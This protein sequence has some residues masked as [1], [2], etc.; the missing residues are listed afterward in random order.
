[1]L[2]IKSI[3]PAPLQGLNFRGMVST[4]A[5]SPSNDSTVSTRHMRHRDRSR[6]MLPPGAVKPDYS[7]Y[8]LSNVPSTILSTFG[9]DG[10]RPTLPKDAFGDVETSG[11]ENVILLL[12]DGLGYNEWKRQSGQGFIGAISK[13]GSVRPMTTVFPSTTA[14]ALTTIST[15]LTPQEHGLPEWFVYMEE[16]GEIIVP[17]PFTR[18]GDSGRDTLVGAFDPRNLFDGQTVF[19]RLKREG[20]SCTSLTNRTLANTAYTKVS[21]AG[22][23]VV[24][25]NT[26][27]DLTV[28][29]RRLVERSRGKNLFYAY[30]SYVDTIEHIYGPGTDEAEVEASLI[31]HA[32][33]EGFLSKLDREAAKKTLIVVTA[34]HG[35]IKIAPE[36]T[37]YMNR[38]GKLA[39]ALERAPSGAMI[40]AW[41][42]ARDAYMRVDPS[43]LDETKEYLE[44]KLAGT[45][46]VLRTEDAMKEGLFGINRPTMKFRRRIGNLM[47]LPHGTKTVWFRYKKGESLDMRGHHGGL[48]ADE[49]TIPLA[50]ARASD[51]Q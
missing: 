49:M 51:I 35:Q 41:G 37:L 10:T 32:F 45:A 11:V 4:S 9:I 8:C 15:G 20:V 28:S 27:S 1:M 17:L 24:A 26:A 18:V 38:F 47:V 40:P 33:Q 23:G 5:R 19:Q 50:A 16:L 43:R 30:W 36:K 14:A 34:D 13:K 48:T 6:S 25:Y 7:R 21:M 3:V 46:S 42:S 44:D 39:K 2:A 12:C 29:L 31:S 22:S